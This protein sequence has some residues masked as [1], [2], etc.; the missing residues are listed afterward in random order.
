MSP[1]K[2]LIIVCDDDTKKYATYLMQLV[3]SCDDDGEN[4]VGVKDATVDVTVWGDKQYEDSM[5]SLSSSTFIL[6]V[7]NGKVAKTARANM[8]LKFDELGMHYGW[9]GTQ[10][11]M[12]VDDA[13]LD[14]DNYADFEAKCREYG[15]LFDGQITLLGGGSPNDSKGSTTPAEEKASAEEASGEHAASPSGEDKAEGA[16]PIDPVMV[17]KA[18]LIPFQFAALVADKA[19]VRVGA[20]LSGREARDRQYSLLAFIMYRDGLSKF[21]GE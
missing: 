12:Y 19:S 4:V 3:S 21:L 5:H 20:F 17:A 14:R 6:F 9:L 16:V 1:K 8:A 11:C 2:K 18:A 13:S 7:G 10:G 15:K